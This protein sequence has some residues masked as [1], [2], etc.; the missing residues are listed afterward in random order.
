MITRRLLALSLMLF[1]LAA[2]AQE[3]SIRYAH[4]VQFELGGPQ[5]Q[6]ARAGGFGDRQGARD[7][8]SGQRRGGFQGRQPRGSAG[9]VVLTFNA[10]ESLMRTEVLDEE[11]VAPTDASHRLGFGRWRIRAA[12]RS[13]NETIVSAYANDADDTFTETR[14][15]MGR[16]FLIRESRPTYEWR[17]VGEESEFLG[18]MVQKA[19]AVKDSTTIEAWFTPQIPVSAGPGRYSGLPGLILVVSVNRGE[20]LYSAIEVDLSGLEEGA[21][22]APKEGHEVTREEY[23]ILVEE[24]LQ[25]IRATH[26]RNR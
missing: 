2:S 1:P 24:K 4:S 18:Y 9:T 26:R 21:I 25:E 6:S 12:S 23:E 13:A 5:G 7:G 19:I 20:E 3:G 8:R 16:T 14:D 15:F 22:V 17:L 10:S 11:Q